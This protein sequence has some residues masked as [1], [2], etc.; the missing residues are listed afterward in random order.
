MLP[1]DI[2]TYV[3]EREKVRESDRERKREIERDRERKREI[4]RDSSHSILV[5]MCVRETQGER[6]RERENKG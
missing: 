3:C 6:A 2:S 5:P 1:L 4:E